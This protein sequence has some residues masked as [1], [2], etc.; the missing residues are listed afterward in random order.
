MATCAG[1]DSKYSWE[2]I[3]NDLRKKEGLSERQI[4]EARISFER[5]INILRR[6]YCQWATKEKACSVEKQNEEKDPR[7]KNGQFSLTGA[8]K[9]LGVT[10]QCL[11]YWIKK[12]WIVPRRDYRDYPVFTVVDIQAIEKWRQTLRKVR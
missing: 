3:A 6:M 8:A 4:E 9:A 12:K 10:R 1:E 5:G 11:Y 2:A 7:R